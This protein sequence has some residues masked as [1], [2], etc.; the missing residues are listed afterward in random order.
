MR[1]RLS[2]PRL[3]PGRRAAARSR[4]PP[5]GRERSFPHASAAARRMAGSAS[6][7]KG[8]T[9]V[10]S[11][12]SSP[13]MRTSRGR[14][15]GSTPS[16]S[17]LPQC[18]AGSTPASRSRATATSRTSAL[19]SSRA[20][21][22]ASRSAVLSALRGSAMSRIPELE[23][24]RN[25]LA[26]PGSSRSTMRAAASR[27]LGSRA[28]AAIARAAS[29]PIGTVWCT[30]HAARPGRRWISLRMV[31]C[32]A[33]PSHPATTSSPLVTPRR[34][35]SST[36]IGSAIMV[37]FSVSWRSNTAQAASRTWG[38]WSPVRTARKANAAG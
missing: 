28:R 12:A 23:L 8:R 4:M 20:V 33:P 16:A 36:R 21:S 7:S 15:W 17:S 24:V 3:A 10:A 11:W 38:T 18:S 37:A 2:A 14:R 6:C 35:C 34:R 26:A 30:H 1:A 19:R 25:R 32:V 5:P 9:G 29:R 27:S 13:S 22:R 31:A